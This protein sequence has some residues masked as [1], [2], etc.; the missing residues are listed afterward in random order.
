[1]FRRRNS[2]FFLSLFSLAFRLLR[3]DRRRFSAFNLINSTDHFLLAVFYAARAR[4]RVYFAC[5]AADWRQSI[6]IITIVCTSK[7]YLSSCYL[8]CNLSFLCASVSVRFQTETY[9][10]H[11][12]KCHPPTHRGQRVRHITVNSKSNFAISSGRYVRVCVLVMASQT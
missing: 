5:R 3:V 8:W 4:Y 1:M 10:T 11:K 6:C 2:F 12:W 7:Y 9:H